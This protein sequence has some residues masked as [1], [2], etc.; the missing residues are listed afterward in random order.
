MLLDITRLF[1]SISDLRDLERR[2]NIARGD[3]VRVYA[4][5]CQV[6]LQHHGESVVAVLSGSVGKRGASALHPSPQE[7]SS[8]TARRSLV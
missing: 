1:E 6:L 7:I 4:L 3:I 5:D 8:I 2:V